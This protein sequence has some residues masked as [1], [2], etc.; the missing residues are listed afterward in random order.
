MPRV[1][2]THPHIVTPYPAPPH[3]P[4]AASTWV[5]CFWAPKTGFLCNHWWLSSALCFIGSVLHAP[6]QSF[7]TPLRNL[8]WRSPIARCR[9]VCGAEWGMLGESVHMCMPCASQPSSK[10]KEFANN[11]TT[12]TIKHTQGIRKYHHTT[13]TTTT[14]VFA[15]LCDHLPPPQLAFW[16]SCLFRVLR[17]QFCLVAGIYLQWHDAGALD[18]QRAAC[19]RAGIRCVCVCV[20]CWGKG[21]GQGL[22]VGW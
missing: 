13:T 3:S 22:I 19:I 18:T 2:Y 1:L 6:M 4:L 7:P 5:P 8:W 12:T 16:W 10:H 11:T 21:G 15:L 9:C 14:T 17:L 20:C